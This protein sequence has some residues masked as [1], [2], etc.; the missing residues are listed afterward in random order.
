MKVQTGTPFMQTSIGVGGTTPRGGGDVMVL[1]LVHAHVFT[2][3]AGVT[4]LYK[5]PRL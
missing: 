1:G 3:L 2:Y 4:A 5:I